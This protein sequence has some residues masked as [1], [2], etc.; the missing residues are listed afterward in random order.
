MAVS[1]E[2]LRWSDIALDEIALELLLHLGEAAVAGPF[3]SH[4]H[5]LKEP[6]LLVR[7]PVSLSRD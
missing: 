2:K 1:V 7:H 4:Q 3:D 5:S 6:C